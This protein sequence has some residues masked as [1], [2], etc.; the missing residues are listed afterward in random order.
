[1]DKPI[2]A[3]QIIE[4]HH[5]EDCSVDETMVAVGITSKQKFYRI[6]KKYNIYLRSRKQ[7]AELGYIKRKE[8]ERNKQWKMKKAHKK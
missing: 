6:V 8:R 7:A 1:M 4:K 5:L 2:I 3:R